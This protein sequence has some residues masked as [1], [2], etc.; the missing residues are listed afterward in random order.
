MQ[1][2]TEEYRGVQR[3]REKGLIDHRINQ[4]CSNVVQKRPNISIMSIVHCQP[5][6]LFFEIWKISIN[7]LYLNCLRRD[8]TLSHQL[9]PNRSRRASLMAVEHSCICMAACYFSYKKGHICLSEEFS[10]LSDLNSGTQVSNG[11][12]FPI[13]LNLLKLTRH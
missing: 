2:S 7:D 6:N 3:S 9:N 11:N 4:G 5:S 12:D 1:R 8:L 10:K 13:Q